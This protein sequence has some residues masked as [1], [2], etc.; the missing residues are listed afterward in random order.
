[1]DLTF[2]DFKAA[3]SPRRARIFIAEKGITVTTVTVD[4]GTAEQLN[5]KYRKINPRCTVPA[6]RIPGGTVLNENIAIATYLETIQPDPPLLGTTPTEKALVLNWNAQVEFEGLW[7]VADALRNKSPG[8]K[9]RALTGPTNYEQIPALVERG[10]DRISRF[11]VTLNDALEGREFLATDRYSFA[12]ITALVTVDFAKR[13][14]VI[15][16]EDLTNLR[17]WRAAVSAR[18]SA[19]T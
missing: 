1:M 9:G 10:T 15:P 11:L 18:P 19:S 3:P 7:A 5:P 14:K 12:D 13:I 4:L 16:G 8:M 2:Y 17:R 6:L